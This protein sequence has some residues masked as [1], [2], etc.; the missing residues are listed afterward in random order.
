MAVSTREVSRTILPT[1]VE[2]PSEWKYTNSSSDST[3]WYNK[4]FDDTNWKTGEGGFG[5]KIG[6]SEKLVK[7]VWDSNDIWLRKKFSL[8]KLS[9]EDIK[10]LVL[11][12]RYDGIFEVYLNGVKADEK[13]YSS[14]HYVISHISEKAKAALNPNGENVI[15]IHCHQTRKNKFIDVGISLL[16]K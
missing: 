7:T 9:A 8:D 3:S 5:S 2:K 11:S 14:L 15:A 6:R 16:T 12:V 4:D 1:S 10:N 13:E